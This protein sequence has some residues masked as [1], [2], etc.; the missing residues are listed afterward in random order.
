MKPHGTVC[1][2]LLFCACLLVHNLA[3]RERDRYLLL[4]SRIIDRAENAVLRVGTARKHPANPL[5]G[6][7]HP[8]EARFDNVYPNVTL[9]REEGVYKIWYK[10]FTRDAVTEDGEPVPREQRV[11]G[12]YG[13]FPR[14]RGDGLCYAVSKDG[15]AWEKPLLDLHPWNGEPSNLVAVGNHGA[16]VYK[17]PFEEDPARRYKMFLRARGAMGVRFSPDGLR[18]SDFIPSPQIAAPG[19]THNNAFW[20]PELGKYVGITRLFSDSPRQRLV[21]RTESADFLNWT[22]AVEVLRGT[23][24][25]QVYSM[26]VFRYA[27]V[28]LGLPAIFHDPRHGGNDR[29]HT[30]LAWSPDTVTWHRIDPGT[31]LIPNAETDGHYDWGCAYASAPVF[32][33]GEIRLYYGAS[34]GPHTDWRDSFLALATLR[35]DGFAG[36][37]PDDKDKPAVVLTRP[38]PLSGATLTITC[39][40]DGGSVTVAVVDESGNVLRQGRPI[41]ADATDRVVRWEA[42]AN[43]EPYVGKAVRLRFDIEGAKLYSFGMK[44]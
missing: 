19:D 21:G 23:P 44:P 2:A 11:R 26:P 32:L 29:T 7:E 35:P 16:G 42:A 13:K 4:D 6:E 9:D 33:D 31:P 12:T 30:E 14:R 20:A 38:V 5:F 41:R 34:N 36:Y 3:A 17:D 10:T 22:K 39:D 15:I 25:A 43:L 40:A 27:G 37:Q 28:Y 8:W 18:W 24:Q 1:L